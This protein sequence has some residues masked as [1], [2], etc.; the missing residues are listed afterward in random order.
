M[1]EIL[2]NLPELHAGQV[3]AF[4]MLGANGKPARFRAIRCGRRWGKSALA[5]V[6]ASDRILKGR[7]QGYFVPAY[8]YQTEIYDELLDMLRPVVKSHNKTEGII[9]CITGGRIEFWTLENDSAGRS[10][11]YHDVYID[12]AAFTKPNMMDIWNRAIQPTLLDYKGTATALSNAN[13]VDP[14]NFFWRIC[15]EPEHGFV[16]FHAPTSSNPYM[17]QDELVRL[18]AERPPLVWKQEYL[19]EFVDWSGTQFFKLENLLNENGAPVEYPTQCAGVFAVIDTATKTGK[20]N[21]GTAVIFCARGAY[22]MKPELTILDYEIC[23]IEG[24]LLEHW[25]PG[26]FSRLE[27]FAAQCGAQIGNLGVWIED[28]ASGMVLLQQGVRRG[29]N[30]HSIDSK[31]TSLG[32]AERAISVSG[33]V[34]QGKVKFSRPVYEKTMIYKGAARNHL[35]QQ[36]LTF[37][38]GVKDMGEDD[39]LDAFCYSVAIALGNQEGF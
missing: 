10:R 32:K 23:Q 3:G 11:K 4:K 37:T 38:L 34:H 8:K 22:G 12:E 30:T 7:I 36:V 21:D 19:A 29:W 13:G 20:T 33:Y 6:L 27:G 1:S 25:L 39:L 16:E 35:M 2:V 26:I 18:E 9:R 5:K 17:P 31:L 14:D 15:N 24:A 28:K